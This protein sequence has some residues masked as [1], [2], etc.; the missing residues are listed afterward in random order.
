MM[1]PNRSNT[2]R[3]VAVQTASPTRLVVML[4]E[5]SIRF[6]RESVTAI[7]A[8]DLDRKRQSIDR[9]VAIVQHLQG[10][11]DMDRGQ[12]VAKDLD[13][14]YTYITDKIMEGSA[15]LQAAPLEEAIKLLHTL[16]TGWEELANKEQRPTPGVPPA[17]LA[18]Q[19][20]TSGGFRLHV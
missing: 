11:L 16:L 17:M 10:T 1:Y 15:K 3:E 9:A 4:Y 19:T 20:A 2:Y 7:N 14:L 12:Q 6:L 8:K 5:G 18:G 13:R